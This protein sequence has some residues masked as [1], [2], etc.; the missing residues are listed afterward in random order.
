MVITLTYSIGN[1]T[2][3]ALSSGIIAHNL[4]IS[5]IKVS[6]FVGGY[7]TSCEFYLRA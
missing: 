1:N 2:I 6:S 5:A 7:I 3:A 4:F